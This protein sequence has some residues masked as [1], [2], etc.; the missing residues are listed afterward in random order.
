MTK[1]EVVAIRVSKK[2]RCLIWIAGL[3][4][5]LTIIICWLVYS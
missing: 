3:N 5:T 4:L 2:L 1:A